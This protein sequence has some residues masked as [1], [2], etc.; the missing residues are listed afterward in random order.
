MALIFSGIL[1]WLELHQLP[2]PVKSY[3]HFDCPGC[4]L[5]RSFLA[6]IAG[7]FFRSFRLHPATV[8]LLLF[9]IFSALHLIYKFKKG[10]I[11]VIYSYIFITMILLGNYIYKSFY[12]HLV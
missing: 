1:R 11:I 9:F 6:L 3:L 4:G 12:H 8:P 5:Q 2:C 10:N 7:D